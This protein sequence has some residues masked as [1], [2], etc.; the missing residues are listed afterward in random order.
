MATVYFGHAKGVGGFER[1][2]AIKVM[3]PHIAGEPEFVDMFLDEARLAAQIHHP[4]VVSTLDV[5]T[6]EDGLFL[7][8][9]YV[10]GTSLRQ[11]LRRLRKQGERLPIGV[12]VAI[13]LDTLAGLHA[14]HELSDT[15][16]EPLN[17]VHRDV[18]PHNILIG[19]DGV[20]RLTDFG[21][22]RASSRLSSTRGGVL[23]GKLTYM[24][25]EQALS[26]PTDR[27][28]DVYSAG[29]V[30][31]EMLTG[32]RLF[33]GDTE[34]ALISKCVMGADRSPRELC[35]AVPEDID[36]VC[37]RALAVEPDERYGTAAEFADALEM[38]AYSCDLAVAGARQVAV[39]G[40]RYK[41]DVHSVPPPP[42]ADEET[43]SFESAVGTLA[44]ASVPAKV[45]GD[46][47]LL[48]SVPPAEEGRE[49]TDLIA[50]A[51]RYGVTPL[52]AAI[53]ALPLVVL[54]VVVAT[55]PSAEPGAAPAG[56]ATAP[57][58][59]T[60]SVPPVVSLRPSVTVTGPD[61][62]KPSRPVRVATAPA[63]ASGAASAMPSASASAAASAAASAS[64]SAAASAPPPGT[65]AE[66]PPTPTA[67]S[68][69]GFEP[70]DL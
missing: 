15:K 42:I 61:A 36:H 24:A 68:V 32:H 22:A 59:S 64:A 35:S 12:T 14:A 5:Q 50:L 20:C 33:R 17:L 26:Q 62:G 27:R 45:V 48:S 10:E 8:M 44:V 18:S 51:A 46:V 30:L 6:G 53:V 69:R 43:G 21:I 47:R 66:V 16:G 67:T 23:K 38:A 4:N 58:A 57:M 60:P 52:R 29:I 54:V 55:W 39:F 7:V 3:H 25:P 40:A 63:D 34:A 65:G 11:V 56:T 13:A 19:T 9:D 37:M 2:V 41:V 28:A 1:R 70:D 49:R 31:W